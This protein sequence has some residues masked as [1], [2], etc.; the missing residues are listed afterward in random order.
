MQDDPRKQAACEPRSQTTQRSGSVRWRGCRQKVD[1]KGV[2]VGDAADAAAATITTSGRLSRSQSAV[3]GLPGQVSTAA[4][5][6]EHLAAARLKPRAPAPRG[7]PMRDARRRK[8]APSG[9]IERQRYCG[10]LAVSWKDNPESR[11]R[12]Y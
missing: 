2:V 1:R 10:G 9:Q 5:G 6:G 3:S 7:P 12:V 4:V 8:P 11:G